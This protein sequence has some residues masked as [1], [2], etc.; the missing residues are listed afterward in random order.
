MFSFVYN[1]IF[2]INILDDLLGP[3]TIV[4]DNSKTNFLNR[5]EKLALAVST[6]VLTSAYP[7]LAIVR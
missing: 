2:R 5:A 4:S 1:F 3:K 6:S 7:A